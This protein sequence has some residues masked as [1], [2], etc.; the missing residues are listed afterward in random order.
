MR[1]VVVKL[2]TKEYAKSYD[3]IKPEKYL[4]KLTLDNGSGYP[5]K[6][7]TDNIDNAIIFYSKELAEA[8]ITLLKSNTPWIL[9]CSTF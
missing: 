6:S 3:D 8:T 2:E 9:K 5:W 7:W 4:S 1:Y